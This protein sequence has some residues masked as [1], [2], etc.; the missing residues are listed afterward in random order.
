MMG[1]N[2]RPMMATLVAATAL[3]FAAP[4]AAAQLDPDRVHDELE[5]FVRD[6]LPGSVSDVAV[7][8]I[9][10]TEALPVPEG[11][12]ALRFRSRPGEDFVGRT[13]LSMDVLDGDA[14]V[15]TRSLSFRVSGNVEVWT[16]AS[17]VGRG[18]PVREHALSVDLRDLDSLAVDAMMSSEEIGN[19]AASR[20]LTMGTVLC[21]SMLRVEPDVERGA[22]VV[23]EIRTGPLTV[24]CLGTAMND[25]AVGETVRA[26]C[27]ETGST[28]N[29]ELTPDGRVV[30]ALPRMVAVGG[31]R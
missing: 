22:A 6:R 13:V 10:L 27:D 19:A 28:I 7:D 1:T 29:G 30:M 11:G 20:D 9:N 5:R 14:V 4:C 2:P 25:G 24:S 21:R 15:Q 23:V 26:R 3:A 31:V 12:V 17:P 18:Q 16:V 8:G